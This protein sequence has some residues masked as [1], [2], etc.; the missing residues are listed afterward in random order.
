MINISKLKS[1]IEKVV[2]P[3]MP[4]LCSLISSQAWCLGNAEKL[5]SLADNLNSLLAQSTQDEL[6]D[7]ADKIVDMKHGDLAQILIYLIS[8][9][10]CLCELMEGTQLNGTILAKRNLLKAKIVQQTIFKESIVKYGCQSLLL[11]LKAYLE[12][13]G[14]LGPE[15]QRILD[16][17]NELLP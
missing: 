13:Q 4:E 16:K 17:I 12:S 2:C 5:Q 3:Q 7:I 14:E 6:L 10:P 8:C 9:V 11:E 15:D 1:E